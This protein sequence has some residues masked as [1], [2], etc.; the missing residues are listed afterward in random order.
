MVG[1]FAHPT[2]ARKRKIKASIKVQDKKQTKKHKLTKEQA[3]KKS[4]EI[5]A[6]INRKK[7]EG[8]CKR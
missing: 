5:I 7:T 1:N 6:K 3:R 8:K 2:S 4:Q